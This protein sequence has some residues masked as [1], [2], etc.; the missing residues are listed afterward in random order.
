[1]IPQTE[2]EETI[3]IAIYATGVG[4]IG[5]NTGPFRF[6]VEGQPP[7]YATRQEITGTFFFNIPTGAKSISVTDYG[8]CGNSFS[9]SI[10][11]DTCWAGSD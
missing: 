7:F 6:D 2:P 4:M 10:P 8:H 1:M 5:K 3:Q 11:D 9:L